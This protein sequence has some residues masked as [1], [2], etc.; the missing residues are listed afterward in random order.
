MP[1]IVP[2]QRP[3]LRRVCPNLI[4]HGLFKIY[5]RADK[6][7]WSIIVSYRLRFN[8]D[9][10]LGAMGYGSIICHHLHQASSRRMTQAESGRARHSIAT[11][12]VQSLR[13]I[14]FYHSS[15]LDGQCSGAILKHRYPQAELYPINYGNPFPWNEIEAADTVFMIDFSLLPEDMV[16]L[17]RLCDLTWIDHHKMVIEAVDKIGVAIKGLRR[18]DDAACELTWEFLFPDVPMPRF[19]R[20]LGRYDV[21][22]QSDPKRWVEEILPF[23]YGMRVRDTD[24]KENNEWWQV[25]LSGPKR[26]DIS[27]VLSQGRAIQGYLKENNRRY[28]RSYSYETTFDGYCALVVNAGGT[29]SLLFE[30]AYDPARHD[31]MVAY[32]CI[33][34][35]RWG[36]SLYSDKVDVAEIAKKYGGAGHPGAS[37]FSCKRLPFDIKARMENE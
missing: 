18:V 16:R 19:I 37:G 36:V 5:Q 6:E 1:R 24:P 26:L 32:C 30:S 20:L 23:Q 29:S 7:S 15:D 27:D 31:L 22:D 8:L 12:E 4:L 35:E 2:G 17:S 3:D 28:M 34:G 21:W 11:L 10:T 9:S 14:C 13:I 25:I 33:R